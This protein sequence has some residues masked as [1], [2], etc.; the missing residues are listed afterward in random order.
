MV[1]RLFF[2]LF[3]LI[4]TVN[5]NNV[6]KEV[7]VN[8]NSL[9]LTF[10]HS[11]KRSDFIA[12]AIKGTKLT[13]YFFD[14]KKCKLSKKVKNKIELKGVVKSIRVAQNR[15]NLVRVV[16]DSKIAYPIKFHQNDGESIF[17]IALPKN[18]TVVKTKTKP[19]S[20]PKP[21]PKKIAA[22]KLF[23]YVVDDSK[24]TVNKAKIIPTIY[25]VNLK[26]K[27]TVVIDPGH[28]GH[29]PGT[30]W[31]R[32]KEKYL[33]MQIAKRVYKRLK[34]LGFNVKM[35]R[36]RD[37]YVTLGGRAR[38]ANKINADL[39]VSIHANS[40]SNMRRAKYAR[41][42]ETYFLQATRN[43]RAKRVAAKEN[44]EILKGKDRATKMVLLKA[45]FTGPK[46]ALSN[47]LAI[48][49]QKGMLA[50][51][52][53]SYKGVRDNGVRGAPFYVLVGAEMPAVLIEVGYLSNPKE[54]ARL[55]NAKYQELQAKGIVEGIIRYL[56][57]RE[58]EL[59]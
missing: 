58:K 50:N 2:I 10:Q 57:N 30:T 53:S 18:V 56:K 32:Y 29:D 43:A 25:S 59:E 6:L 20:K 42:I 40:V 1:N 26:H 36:Y 5:G 27:Y 4:V 52:R 9:D 44:A 22:K 12:S 54:R 21:K 14:F 41:G 19:K 28:G 55:F 23:S 45:V 15:R 49:I 38:K 11:L 46:I 39:F 33:V 37:K 31:G 13:R 34:N 47:K 51:L 17:H 8:K 24:K 7:K 16:I 3:A 35:T 48:D